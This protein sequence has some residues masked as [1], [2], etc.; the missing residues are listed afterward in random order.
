MTSS[1]EAAY[2]EDAAAAARETP[3]DDEVARRIEHRFGRVLRPA[4]VVRRIGSGRHARHE[5]HAADARAASGR[6]C[7][8]VLST[9]WRSAH[10]IGLAGR[11]CGVHDDVGALQERR[12][13]DIREVDPTDSNTRKAHAFAA[14]Q[15][16]HLPPRAA[17]ATE[18]AAEETTGA[19]HDDRGIVMPAAWSPTAAA[20]RRRARS[21]RRRRSPLRP[22]R[23]ARAAGLVRQEVV[24]EPLV[25]RM[26]AIK[27]TRFRSAPPGRRNPQ[28]ASSMPTLHG[29]RRIHASTAASSGAMGSGK[30]VRHAAT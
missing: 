5:D 3:T 26:A 8:A 25:S 1:R 2:A 6:R 4:V 16:A 14:R 7:L 15:R 13:D 21:P 11:P 19:R 27:S 17:R 22:G 20:P 9:F 10:R 12:L 29:R 18:M 23:R 28:A 24:R 30:C